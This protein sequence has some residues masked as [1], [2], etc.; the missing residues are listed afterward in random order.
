MS[1]T[2]ASFAV[3]FLALITLYWISPISFRKPLLLAAGLFFYAYW[4][5]KFLGLMGTCIV[6]DYFLARR[7]YEAEARKV[8]RGY[9]VASAVLNFSLLGFFKYYNFF[10][11]SANAALASLGVH[12][13][14]LDV[15]LPVGI[16]FFTFESMSYTFDVY[17]GTLIPCDRLL[18]FALFIAFFPRLVA[19]PIIRASHFLPQLQRPLVLRW[20]DIQTGSSIFLSGLVKKLLFADNLAPFVDRIYA[21]PQLYHPTTVWLAAFG[22]ALQIYYDFSGYS[23]MAV[24]LAKMFGFDLPINFSAP[25]GARNITEFWRR[26]HI[27]LST[28]LR[29]YLYIPLGGN[30]KGTGRT[31][32][33]LMVTMLLGGLWHGA[34]W[35]FVVWGGLHGVGLAAHKWWTTRFQAF[36]LPSSVARMLTVLFVVLLWVPFRAH[37]WNT[38][39]AIY[40]QL[41]W[42]GG[43]VQWFY[44]WFFPIIAICLATAVRHRSGQP[45]FLSFDTGT[46]WGRTQV[47]VAVMSLLYLSPLNISPFVYFQF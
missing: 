27:S 43:G 24:G 41:L 5:W 28:W 39:M 20:D 38:A 12:I 2:S 23:D 40:H 10:A 6:A 11:G 4:N 17:R 47:A 7:I 37:D 36:S 30:R 15:I 3:F 45:D 25:Y 1:F 22:Y 32:V 26:W 35:N 29:D 34:S 19:G 18:D 8:R 21:T 33:N 9:M 42:L 46:F 14:H 31:Y 44:P 13:P 16:S